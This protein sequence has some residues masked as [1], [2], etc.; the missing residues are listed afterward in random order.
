MCWTCT[1]NP[2]NRGN[3]CCA[4]PRKPRRAKR[5]D[6]K[7]ERH[8]VCNAFM[9]FQPLAGWR[10]MKVTEQRTKQDFAYIVRHVVDVYFRTLKPSGWSWIS[11]TRIVQPPYMKSFHQK[12]CGA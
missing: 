9:L 4:L 11:S 10:E 2:T 8:G 3:Q 1:P 6:Y 12:K 5:V 7:Y